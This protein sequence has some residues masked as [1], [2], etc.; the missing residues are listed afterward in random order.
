[1]R[2]PFD[3]PGGERVTLTTSVGVALVGADGST[4]DLLSHADLALYEAKGVGRDRV[5]CYDERLHARTERRV[6]AEA[7]LRAALAAAD[8]GAPGAGGL[9]VVLQ[10]VVALADG[11]GRLVPRRWSAWPGPDGTDL[12]TGDLVEVAEETG[13]VAR[14]DRWVMAEVVRLLAADD[15]RLAAGRPALLP[16]RVAVNVSGRS[17]EDPG[18]AARVRALLAE[19]GVAP[20]RLAVEL[21]ETSLLHDTGAVEEAVAELVAPRG[22]GRP[23]RL[24]HGL[25]RA[26]LPAPVPAEL[27][28]DRHVVRPARW[29]PTRRADA[30]VAAVV[31]LAH[32]HDLAVVAEGV[33]T[34]EQA[35]ALRAMGCEHG[36]GLAVRPARGGAAP[37]EPCLGWVAR[38]DSRPGPPAPHPPPALTPDNPFAAPS[39]LPYGLP[40]F[41]RHPRGAPG[42]GH[43]GRARGAAGGVGGRGHPG[44]RAD[45]RRARCW[46]WSAAAA[47]CSGSA[48]S[49]DALSSAHAT[50]GVR[51]V[52][53]EFAPLRAAHAD[54]LFLDA[55][56]L[57]PGRRPARP[58]GA[59]WAWPRT[60]CACSSATTATSSA[61]APPCPRPARTGCARSTP[62]CPP[63]PSASTPWSPT[64]PTPPRS[65]SPTRPETDGLSPDAARRRPRRRRRPRAGRLAASPWCCP[66]RSPR[67]PRCATGT[68]AA[69]CT[70]PPSAA[71][72]SGATDT[73]PLLTRTAA[74]R[75]ER[76]GLF[77]FDSHAD[78]VLDDQTAGLGGRGG[79]RAVRA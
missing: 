9:R 4:A 67:W 31:E 56:R 42:P 44:R 51:A 13:L 54:A 63:C 39:T 45:L 74:L 65:T 29:A 58:P 59:S 77:G 30:V 26:G 72:W 76:A 3:L 2:D 71:G 5:A 60:S 20:A 69:G 14:L 43:G 7:L 34:A 15:A 12:H 1:M 48:R 6:R 49:L 41:D 79:P 19:H 40:P 78:Y 36:A 24:R 32:A 18:F 53:A 66:P 52:D 55:R 23:R 70:R 25:L 35:D 21:T 73:R 10:P 33:E 17:I 11:A 50:P 37:A 16:A 75:A 22:P 28:Q 61:P 62:S 38:D 64:P 8:A 57:R 68:S 27:P 47:C 46:P